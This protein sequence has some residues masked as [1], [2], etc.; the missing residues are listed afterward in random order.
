M[1]YVGVDLHKRFSQIFGLDPDTGEVIEERV[2]NDNS[3][4]REFFSQFGDD[5]KVA[6][7]A[8]RSWYWFVDLL[9][10]MELDVVL[11]NPVQT[12]AIAYAKVKTDKVDAK[13]LSHLLRSDLLP[14][15]WIPDRE[16]RRLREKL[17]MRL[18]LVR[19]GTQLKNLVR[20]VLA[21]LNIKLKHTDIWKGEGR[22]ELEALDLADPYGKILPQALALIDALTGFID[23]WEA[24]V[25]AEGRGIPEC[26][27][28]KTAPGIGDISALTILY[29]SGPIDRFPSCKSYSS[30][31][32]FAPKVKGSAGKFRV[33]HLSKQANMYLK[34]IYVE[35]ANAIVRSGKG[36]LWEYYRR[37]MRKK[38]KR[39]AKIAL[40]RK[41]SRMV[42]HM[43]KSQ[44]DYATFQRIGESR[45]MRRAG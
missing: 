22:K 8:T 4:L 44:I 41:I 5:S 12:K 19:V 1:F 18:K 33:G 3:E 45:R 42:Y 39:V 30:Y 23:S 11:S 32:G 37:I 29:E 2:E 17:R 28:L 35:I 36:P 25:K 15:S 43:I 6:L 21:K 24:D 9:Q 38:G 27:L 40:A 20:S 14:L 34:W 31:A 16:Q 26:R 10:E 7:E 13:M